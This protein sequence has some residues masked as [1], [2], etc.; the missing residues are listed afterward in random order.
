MIARSAAPDVPSAPAGP[1]LQSAP[2][3]LTLSP[4]SATSTPAVQLL[5]SPSAYNDLTSLAAPPT[6]SV[7]LPAAQSPS[8]GPPAAAVAAGI[9][10]ALAAVAA[11]AA[12]VIILRR[13]GYFDAGAAAASG[14]KPPGP[15]PPS[16]QMVFAGGMQPAPP[17]F[18]GYGAAAGQLPAARIGEASPIGSNGGYVGGQQPHVVR[19]GGASL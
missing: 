8:S 11:A 1:E 15:P 12:A 19:I 10:V 3:A 5:R 13:R 2:E 9:V 7:P 16:C 6:A 14:I 18:V 17:G 4:P